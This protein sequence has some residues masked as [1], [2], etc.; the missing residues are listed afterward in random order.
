[1]K[2]LLLLIVTF[3]SFVGL[4]A[5]NLIVNSDMESGPAA[6]TGGGCTP[7]V[8]AVPESAY[9][10]PSN[11]NNIAEVDALSC[12]QQ[13]VNI[14]TNT[15]YIISFQAT[16]RTTCA[17]DLGPNP[18]INVKITGV[19]S[20]TVYSSVNYHYNNPDDPTPP[21][22]WVGY[23][24]EFQGVSIP[25]GVTDAQVRIDIT[26]IDN[27]VDCGIVM[28]NITMVQGTLAV[29]LTGFNASA[30]GS[31]V[32]LSWVTATETNSAF[33]TVLRSKDGINFDEVGKVTAAG[34]ASTYT[35]TDAQPGAGIS[36]YKLRM[37]DKNGSF[38]YSSVVKVNLSVKQMDVHVYPTIVSDVLNYA[39]EN[40]KAT[41][42]SVMVTDLT[43]KRVNNTVES[44]GT[45]TT[46][47]SI[48]VANLASG[49][50]F[51]TVQE[52]GSGFKKSVL[53]K[54]N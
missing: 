50:Y 18:G 31:S 38:R 24:T 30:K 37:V 44:F 29:N 10:G 16:R 42:L 40:P 41:K 12:L 36:Y 13:I 35:L 19:T 14:S 22:G 2:K 32:D 1:M 48:N 26:A 49:V 17:P 33:F 4:R 3:C 52:E 6:W 53:F 39:V 25:N 21:T 47:K 51:L 23:T 43:G 54:K 15:N 8:G 5:Q 20:G 28:D 11:T 34:F 46:Q 9:G 45:G 7:E 27:F